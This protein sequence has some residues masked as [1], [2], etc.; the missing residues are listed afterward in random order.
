MELFLYRESDT[1]LHRLDARI[2]ILGLLVIFTL[3]LLFSHPLLLLLFMGA[4]LSL[5]AM[6]RCLK[7][8]RKMWVLL[9]LL[10][11]YCLLL[12]PMFIKGPLEKTVAFGLGMGLRLDAMLMAGVIVASTTR[13]EDFTAGL[14]RLG[15]PG[16]VAFALSLAF[17]WVPTFLGTAHTIVLAQQARGLD[18]QGGHFLDRARRYVPLV[19]PLVAHAIRQTRLLAMALEAKGFN[20]AASRMEHRNAPFTPLDVLVLAA[21]ALLLAGGL[22]SRWQGYGIVEGVGF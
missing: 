21:L 9:L 5:A 7:N 17:R 8:L 18:L 20:P 22:W 16:P 19:L 10:L 3:A 2:K 15:L 12:W 4:V 6:G 11:L 13:V 14:Q 1:A